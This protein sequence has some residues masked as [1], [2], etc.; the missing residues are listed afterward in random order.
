[1]RFFESQ[2]KTH[3]VAIEYFESTGFIL[4]LRSEAAYDLVR[5]FLH[6]YKC[7]SPDPEMKIGKFDYTEN[8][9]DL[10]FSITAANVS[11]VLQDFSAA[12]IISPAL[13]GKVQEHMRDGD[14]YQ[15]LESERTAL[16]SRV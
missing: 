11:T 3:A 13:Y 6:S 12:R 2:K 5:A 9:K 10:T 7:F 8:K 15:S 14:S 4:T 16:V 1:M